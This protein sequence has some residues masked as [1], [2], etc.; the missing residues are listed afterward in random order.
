MRRKRL[1]IFLT[2]LAPLI[3]G[4]FTATAQLNTFRSTMSLAYP[5]PSILK[6]PSGVHKS[7][8]IFLHGLGDTGPCRYYTHW[9]QAFAGLLCIPPV[10]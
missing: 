9:C 4:S 2:S 6:P 3:A 7:T 10:H 5:S 1:A 8:L